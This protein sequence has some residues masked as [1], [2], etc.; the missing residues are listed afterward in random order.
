MG[1][2]LTEAELVESARRG[3]QDAYGELVSAYQGIAFRTAYLLTGN[4]ADAEDAAQDAFVKAFYA[5]GVAVSQSIAS[6]NLTQEELAQV[7]LGFSDGALG[8]TPTGTRS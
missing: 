8:K 2:P 7:K 5:L 4:A 1:L 6:F 3:D